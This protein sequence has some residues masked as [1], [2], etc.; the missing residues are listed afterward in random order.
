MTD[1]LSGERYVSVSSIKPVIGHIHSDALAEKDDDVSLAKDIKH[2]IC[3]NLDSRY[4]NPKVK[5][6]L[7]ITSFLGTYKIQKSTIVMGFFRI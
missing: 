3:T 6:L 5:N 4:L 2:C 7:D 1:L